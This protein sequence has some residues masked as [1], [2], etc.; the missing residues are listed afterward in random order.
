MRVFHFSLKP[1][2][3]LIDG[4]CIAIKSS[5]KS[6]ILHPEIDVHHFTLFTKKHPF[7]LDAYPPSWRKSIEIESC[8][9]D[10]K[11]DLLGAAYHLMLNKSYNLE[12]FNQKKVKKR[13]NSILDN[14]S[15][16]AVILES[17]FLLPYASI[18]KKR[19]ISVFVRTHNVEF[20]IWEQLAEESKSALKKWYLKKLA[21]QLKEE[22]IK[23]LNKVDGIISISK[24]D[25]LFFKESLDD[26]VDIATIATAVHYPSAP[27]DVT[28]ND[29]YFLGAMDWK[30]NIEGVN[31]LLNDVFQNT[32]LPN[33]FHLAGKSLK[34][35]QF[36]HDGL[37]CHGE[38]PDALTFIQNHGICLIPLKS[39]S[40]IKIKLLE[41]M[42]LGKPIVTTSEG[43]K[44]VN[45]LSGTHVLIADTPE[46]FK[47]AMIKLMND[48]IL[49][50][51]LGFAAYQ[52][53]I[54]NFDENILTNRLVEFITKK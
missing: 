48:E 13:I 33:S 2:F 31:W 14:Y 19:G 39:G 30:P 46:E 17:A 37:I 4:G 5:L 7:D 50:K 49:R 15:F 26:S 38:I 24:L 16:D 52:F 3:P 18:F 47:S 10:T 1:A 25:S 11:T 44:G 32:A 12:R 28:K 21:A 45:V 36:K 41:N 23:G 40:G 43:A 42:A 35:N 8:F 22:E 20:K 6:L 51:D 54:N 29:F 9:I 53:V 27:A 34:K